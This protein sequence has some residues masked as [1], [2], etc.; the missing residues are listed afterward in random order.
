MRVGP[1]AVHPDFGPSVS[2][3]WPQDGQ[4]EGN[5]IESALVD[6]VLGLA[7]TQLT[8]RN[9]DRHA[10]PWDPKQ[11]VRI[12]VLRPEIQPELDEAEDRSAASEGDDE[13]NRLEA[14]NEPLS[15]GVDF[16][17]EANGRGTVE[18]TI[19][20][21]FALYQ[22][23]L[24]SLDEI[25]AQVR[26][27]DGPQDGDGDS[28]GQGGGPTRVPVPNA[29]QRTNVGI[30]RLQLQVPTDG[31]H[32]SLREELRPELHRLIA[33]HF[34]RTDAARPFDGPRTVAVSAL[35]E[36]SSW[37]R[38]VAERID[39]SWQP[40]NP[41]PVI[42]AF[43][44]RLPDG[45][46]LVS[47][48]LTNG[49]ITTHSA[50]QDHTFYDCR[51]RARSSTDE[52]VRQRFNLA[53]DDYRYYDQ[54]DVIGHGRN[55][56]AVSTDEGIASD[57]LPRHVQWVVR[58]RED[59]IPKL[60]WDDLAEAPQSVLA[61][62][63][64][65]MRTY[66]NEW[67]GFLRRIEDPEVH[68]ASAKERAD[69]AE[70]IKRFALGRALLR[71]D[72]RLDTAFRLANRS[73]ALANQ[74]EDY[75]TWHLFQLV[76]IVALLGSIAAREHPDDQRL[77]DELD[78]ADVLWFPTGGGKTEAYLGLLTVAAF[79]DRLRGKH[80]GVTAW[81]RFPLRMLSVQQ[82]ARVLRI[83]V[84]ADQIRID[85][86]D[87]VGAPFE[88]GYLVGSGNTP[89]ELRYP[90]K[91]WPGM[92]HS[93]KLTEDNRKRRRLIAACPHCGSKDGVALKP[94]PDAVRLLHKCE[95]CDQTLPIHMTDDEVYRY[96]PTVIVSTIDKITGYAHF[97]DFTSFNWGPTK[98]CPD[99]GFHAFGCLARDLCD[100]TARDMRSVNDWHDPVPS[101]V[102][103]DELHLVREEL[104]T[105]DAHFE[106]LI[107]ELQRG[108]PSGMSSKMLAATATI[109]QYEDQLRQVYGRHPRRF[110]SPGF[111]R[112][113]S[114]YTEQTPNVRRI[115]M[116]VMPT[117]GGTS[118]VEVA[119]WLQSAMVTAINALQDDL[120]AC[121]NVIEDLAGQTLKDD[122]LRDL[123][124]NYEASLSY[125]NNRGHGSSIADDLR[126]L[127]RRLEHTT[128]DRLQHS[129]LTGDV[130]IAELAAAI[131]RI[132]EA[133]PHQPRSERLRALVGTS[134][135]SHGV[136]I[137]RLN[138]MVMTGMPSTVADYIQA[139]SRSGRR[140]VGTI[141]TVFDHFARREASSFTHFESMHRFL[142]RMVEPVP[143][144]K[145]ARHAAER[146]LPAIVMALLWDMCRNPDHQGPAGGIYLTRHFS[147]WWDARAATL[148]PLLR[149]RIDRV[150]RAAA[151]DIADKNLEDQLAERAQ[152][153]WA[154]TE[155]PQVA[156]YSADKTKELFL[157]RVMTSLRDVDEAVGF[158]GMPK[159]RRVY[160][161]LT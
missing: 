144:N 100:R 55:C 117:G 46:I 61:P 1:D 81:L 140:H 157:E 47:V 107:T 147:R 60:R 4:R 53:P 49:T 93:D 108:G 35:R 66:L 10:P 67:D 149:E 130:P 135:V 27:Q 94:D 139:T 36:E 24:P 58:P 133:N 77:A 156:T 154:N 83:L 65:A 142:E 76:Y 11:H 148:E 79:Y 143:V 3:G 85:E 21:E 7:A 2:G 87:G 16:I 15:I 101:F 45:D 103:Q 119:G 89:N 96:Q 70:E 86:L 62:V 54:A 160:D 97:G 80:R 74:D 56:V 52:I 105:F 23:L 91:W 71:Q 153:R 48:S 75:D 17:V 129:V 146:T 109:E 51:L 111:T 158:T 116:G 125:V 82:L 115:F 39:T 14:R 110:P 104:G 132:E 25:R 9:G 59:H 38:A 68:A 137:S 44:E 34:G 126:D 128:G 95:D 20:A 134:V 155:S 124:F 150:Y 113:R 99:H 32:V 141:V 30:D 69:F 90:S 152:Q 120:A 5:A 73:F 29:W 112:T 106:G 8:D 88:L 102:I 22:P 6:H 28:D 63:E 118:K 13:D 138:T 37:H 41:V 50:F 19:D 12:G 136:D 31:R 42:D 43:A 84:A 78:H 98:E 33:D 127:S 161:A 131:D 122:Q 64:D 145:Y 92:R 72:R 26:D 123:L 121:R 57:T 159:S 18:L 114:F 40:E 151:D